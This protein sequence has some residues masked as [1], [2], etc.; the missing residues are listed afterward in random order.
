V[1]RK[2][3]SPLDA[4]IKGGDL[5]AQAVAVVEHH[6]QDRRVM[7]GEKPAQR[8]LEPPGV[9]ACPAL[10]QLRQRPRIALPGD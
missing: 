4:G 10:G 9:L 6:L 7:I 2:G 8:L 3:R 1:P 5:G